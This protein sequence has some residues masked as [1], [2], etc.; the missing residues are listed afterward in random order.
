MSEHFVISYSAVDGRDFALKLADDLAAG[1]PT[2]SVWI[3]KR[4]L[5]PSEDWDEQIVEAIRA[6]KGMIF[7]M[8]QDSVRINS[9][10]KMG[11]SIKI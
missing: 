5:R 9:V 4:N 6:C 10:C 7:I 2:V 8:T 11:A 3:D 1:P